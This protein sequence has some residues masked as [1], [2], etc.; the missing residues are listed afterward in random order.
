[1]LSVEL[2]CEGEG[3]RTWPQLRK[4]ALNCYKS[5]TNVTVRVR[6]SK[7]FEN[8]TTVCSK[9]SYF[10]FYKPR[11]EFMPALTTFNK[12]SLRIPFSGIGD[13]QRASA[14][15]RKKYAQMR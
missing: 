2:P 13:I 4:G 3:A 15:H 5:D 6:K 10:R 1:M 7:I 14:Y 8:K 11:N 12:T 9:F